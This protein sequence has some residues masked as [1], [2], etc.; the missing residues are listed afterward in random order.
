MARIVNLEV[1]IQRK[2]LLEGR[3]KENKAIVKKLGRKIN[4][5]ENK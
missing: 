3:G 1:L 5:L 4:K 2:H